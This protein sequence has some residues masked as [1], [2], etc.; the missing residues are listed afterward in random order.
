M[1]DEIHIE[2]LK[3]DAVIGVY[4]SEKVNA[5]PLWVDVVLFTDIVKPAKSDHLEDA[6]DYAEIAKQIQRFAA[7]NTCQLLEGF[8][9][10][11][12]A[13][14]LKMTQ[15]AELRVSVSKPQAIENARNTKLVIHRKQ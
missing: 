12:A 8:I 9:E 10:R 7:Q 11:L 2:Q 14:L 13:M 6:L 3:V 4:E 15:C 5:Q 1:Y